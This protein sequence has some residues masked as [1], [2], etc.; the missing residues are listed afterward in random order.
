MKFTETELQGAYVI[1]LEPISDHRG[2]FARSF[3]RKEFSEHDL[4]PDIMQ[5][6][7]S[8]NSTKGTLRGMHYQQKPF[9]ECKLIRC[10]SGAIHDVIIDMRQSSTTYKK[11]LSFNLNAKAL[12]MLYIPEGFAHGFITLEDNT[13]VSYNMSEYYQNNA[14]KGIRYNDP[15]FKINWPLKPE[16]ISEKDSQYKDF[17]G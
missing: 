9:G 15:E 14:S 7:I 1:E 6:N 12:T 13:V 4:N 8:Y 3:C 11:W 2:Y 16:I 5:Q 10:L 17:H